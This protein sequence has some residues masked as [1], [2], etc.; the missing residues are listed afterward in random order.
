[1][2][3][4]ISSQEQLATTLP[5]HTSLEITLLDRLVADKHDTDVRRRSLS[6]YLTKLTRLGGCLARSSD[7]PPGNMLI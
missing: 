3:V 7:L 4:S 2:I 5:V 6:T 1:M